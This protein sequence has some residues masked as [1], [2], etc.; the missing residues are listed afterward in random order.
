MVRKGPVLKGG[1][2]Y[3]LA[4]DGSAIETEG[5]RVGSGML[6]YCARREGSHPRPDKGSGKTLE[7]VDC[8]D[9]GPQR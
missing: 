8:R 6:V 5:T 4:G 3:R 1:D 2:G 9:I 7:D